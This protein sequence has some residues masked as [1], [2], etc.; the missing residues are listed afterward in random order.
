MSI[1]LPFNPCQGT[2]DKIKAFHPTARD[3]W[4]YFAT[5]TK[6]IYCGKN[7]EYIPMGGN[8]GI[9]YGE[10]IEPE[11]VDSDVTIFDFKESEITGNQIPSIDDLILNIPNGCFY[12]VIRIE[13]DINEKAIITAERLTI[14]GGSSGSSPG[15]NIMRLYDSDN[16][17]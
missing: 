1:R 11:G 14:S 9:Y 12:R 17:F 5:D 16:N 2:E 13:Y 4:V 6:K 3:G 8:S 7:G 10:M 15:R